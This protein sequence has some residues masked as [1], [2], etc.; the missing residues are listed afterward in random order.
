MARADVGTDLRINESERHASRQDSTVAALPRGGLF[1]LLV[2]TILIYSFAFC[3]KAGERGFFPL[4]QSIEFDGGYRILSGQVPY[5]DFVIPVGPMVFVLQAFVFMLFG[6]NFTAFLMGA[7]IVNLIATALSMVVLSILFPRNRWP[8]LIAGFLTATW[9]YPPYGTPNMEQTAFFFS[10][11]GITTLLAAVCDPH[12]PRVVQALL[13]ALAGACTVLGFLSKQNAGLVILPVYGLLLLT[14]CLPR[15]RQ[16]LIATA[17]FTAGALVSAAVFITWLVLWS[18][19]ALFQEHFFTIPSKLGIGR[20]AEGRAAL[21]GYLLGGN[22]S[23]LPTAML[24]SSAW[25]VI[26]LSMIVVRRSQWQEWSKPALAAMLCIYLQFFQNAF[27][28]T[29][30]NQWQECMPFVGL[31]LGCATGLMMLILQRQADDR[32]SVSFTWRAATC[33]LGGSIILT[34]ISGSKVPV[35]AAGV[36]LLITRMVGLFR[37]PS[38]RRASTGAVDAPLVHNWRKRREQLAL[39]TIFVVVGC[40]FQGIRAAWIRS[41]HDIFRGASFTEESPVAGLEHLKWGN[42][43][44]VKNADFTNDDLTRLSSD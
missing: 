26:T 28:I 19:P 23:F 24:L 30:G 37:E 10:L 12:W 5:K 38:W 42:P 18:D 8:A 25:G 22:G 3:F 11:L 40:G 35:I 41:V 2:A 27:G 14:A 13:C 31:I 15:V 16:L 43:T 20:L 39:F 1:W 9:F 17:W 6:V 33:L 34:L 44:V 4:D 29:T 32:T 7:A 36:L 21:L